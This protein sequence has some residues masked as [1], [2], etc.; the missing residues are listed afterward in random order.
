M[1]AGKRWRIWHIMLQ[2]NTDITGTLR[3]KRGANYD[4]FFAVEFGVMGKIANANIG[5]N[6]ILEE[7]ELINSMW[8]N[9]SSG[10]LSFWYTEE[11]A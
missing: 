1:P 7:G 9:S 11:D 10:T 3:I 5:G 6:I 2:S 8:S 4:T